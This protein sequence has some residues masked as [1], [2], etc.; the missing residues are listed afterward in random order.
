MEASKRNYVEIL[1]ERLSSRSGYPWIYTRKL[2]RNDF[3]AERKCFWPYIRIERF[4]RENSQ[5]CLFRTCSSI[6]CSRPIPLCFEE[7]SAAEDEVL[8][9]T[10]VPSSASRPL[11]PCSERVAAAPRRRRWWR[12]RIWKSP[13]ELANFRVKGSGIAI[14]L[15]TGRAWDYR[16]NGSDWIPIVYFSWNF[17]DGPLRWRGVIRRLIYCQCF[18]DLYV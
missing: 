11:L 16:F 10:R 6:F 13:R 8:R 1:E 3:L 15:R 18:C 12:R 17:K 4:T 9:A 2:R 7:R 5:E 14:V